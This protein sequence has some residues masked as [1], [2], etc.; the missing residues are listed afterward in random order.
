MRHQH[1]AATTQNYIQILN[2]PPTSA[3][4]RLT[5]CGGSL[6]YWPY[7]VERILYPA[8]HIE[9]LRIFSCHWGFCNSFLWELFTVSSGRLLAVGNSSLLVLW[10][11]VCRCTLKP[12]GK[13]TARICLMPVSRIGHRIGSIKMRYP[14]SIIISPPLLIWSYKLLEWKTISTKGNNTL[15]LQTSKW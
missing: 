1:R 12:I 9:F 15:V 2:Y 11:L 3:N 10:V 7:P 4:T 5:G 13:S 8:S 6:E 14:A